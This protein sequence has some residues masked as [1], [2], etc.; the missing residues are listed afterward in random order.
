M[1]GPSTLIREQGKCHN[2]LPGCLDVEDEVFVPTP[3]VRS[4]TCSM[5]NFS[6]CSELFQSQ[7]IGVGSCGLS[8]V[9]VQALW[10]AA[11]ETRTQ[12]HT[13]EEVPGGASLMVLHAQL[14]SINL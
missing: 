9:A 5:N 7:V 14:S 3:C 2:Y 6:S 13:D 10:P 11:Q 1:E 8:T 4:S 12:L